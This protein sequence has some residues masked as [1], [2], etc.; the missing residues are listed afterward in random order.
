MKRDQ[1]YTV[2]KCPRVGRVTFY[3]ARDVAHTRA[4]CQSA[5]DQELFA[6][7][8][9]YAIERQFLGITPKKQVRFVSINWIRTLARTQDTTV[10][11][12]D[13]ALWS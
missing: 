4:G 3:P 6:L 11:W 7:P 9:E 13:E 8:G 2:S 10:E 5:H 12:V 1:G